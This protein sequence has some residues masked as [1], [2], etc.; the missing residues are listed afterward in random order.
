[1]N[2][3]QQPLEGVWVI[4]PKLMGDHRG[5]FM[6]SYKKELFDSTIG[7]THFIQENE[8]KS[9]YGVFRGLHYQ[10]GDTAQAK[11]VRVLQGSVLDIILDLRQDSPTF[12][13]ML[14]IELSDQ[15]HRQ[16]FVPRGF[17]HGFLVL[18]DSAIFSYKVD[19][20]YNPQTEQC[21]RYDDPE[22]GLTLNIDSA[23]LK[24]S[25]KDLQGLSLSNA[26]TF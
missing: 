18:S 20:P 4:E 2:F 23:D 21:I 9:N 19:N 26:P 15:N 1:M 24:L 11:L 5:Y 16:L 10:T 13:K 25:E 8:S 6:E 14:C 3:I 7:I 22:L 12:K 17:A